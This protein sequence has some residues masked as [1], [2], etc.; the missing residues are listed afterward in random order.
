M[1][2]RDGRASA[3]GWRGCGVRDFCEYGFSRTRYGRWPAD[4]AMNNDDVSAAVAILDALQPGFIPPALFRQFARLAVLPSFVVVPLFQRRSGLFV[5]LTRRDSAD[6]DY[7]GQW[8]PPG[9]VIRPSDETLK[10]CFERLRRSELSGMTL[11]D[12]PTFFDMAFTQIVRGRELALLHWVEIV[13][14]DASGSFPVADLPETTIDTD[15]PRIEA[16]ADHF[17]KMTDRRRGP[18]PQGS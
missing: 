7:P 9:T 2:D 1:H 15:V 16:A 6:P 11:V 4:G 10:A 17:V 12:G 3:A 13:D 8:H 14:D 18:A 5:R